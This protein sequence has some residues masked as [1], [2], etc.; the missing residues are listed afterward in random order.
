MLIEH[1]LVCYVNPS[2]FF[3]GFPTN[4]LNCVVFVRQGLRDRMNLCL[5]CLALVDMFYVV[6][7]SLSGSHCWVGFFRPDLE[8]WWKWSVRSNL[9]GFYQ[10]FQLS[11]GCLT[12]IISVERCVCVFMPLKASTLVKTRT[13]G[14]LILSTVF[15]VQLLCLT[16][17]LK[18][19]VVLRSNPFTNVTDYQLFPSSLYFKHQLIFDI[20]QDIVTNTV[21]PLFTF[22]VVV[23]STIITVVQLKRTIAWRQSSSSSLQENSATSRQLTLVKT[24][25]IVSCIFIFTSSP[26]V[27]FSTS[28]LLEPEFFI[29][30]R[31]NNLF[32]VSYLLYATL[33]LINSSIN[34]FVYV[35]RSS[36]YREELRALPAF[37][38]LC[39]YVW[40]R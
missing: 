8:N 14:L 15:V 18:M 32:Y 31:Y 2:V 22:T 5:F 19:D 37:R 26:I 21:I 28:S 34:F 4:I 6:L 11:S 38:S 39:R 13:I 10:G 24:L 17:S 40:M 30:R 12:T 23:V 7:Y 29:N 25:V 9:I 36:R 3:V 27:A 16:Y 35:H 1:V 33:C 20:I